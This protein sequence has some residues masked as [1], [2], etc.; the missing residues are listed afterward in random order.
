MLN[1]DLQQDC[2]ALT[3]GSLRQKVGHQFIQQCFVD[4]HTGAELLMRLESPLRLMARQNLSVSTVTTLQ[5]VKEN[6][7]CVSL[8]INAFEKICR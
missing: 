7:H 8:V 2:S 3:T 6:T 1:G 4:L 5:P